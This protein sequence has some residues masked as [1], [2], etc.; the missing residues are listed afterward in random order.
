MIYFG[1]S[2][3]QPPIYQRTPPIYG[4][5]W[6]IFP[7]AGLN[8]PAD[9]G[10]HDVATRSLSTAHQYLEQANRVPPRHSFRTSFAQDPLNWNSE[11]KGSLRLAGKK[12]TP[13]IV[14]RRPLT[15]VPATSAQGITLLK[16][17]VILTMA[18]TP[19]NRQTHLSLYRSRRNNQPWRC[20]SSMD[21]ASSL[22]PGYYHHP[23]HRGL[24]CRRQPSCQGERP[25][26]CSWRR[27]A[28]H[29]HHHRQQNRVP[30]SQELQRY[31]A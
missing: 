23:Q 21:T 28:W 2:R 25:Q 26:Y 22:R 20:P 10:C 1:S 18:S 16:P 30:R 27:R 5:E 19:W 7:E 29:F 15:T 31:P 12:R 6:Q 3:N 8:W 14:Y 4:D 13:P 17:S 9:G 24:H 11:W